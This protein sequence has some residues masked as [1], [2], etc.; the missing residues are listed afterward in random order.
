ME[1]RKS[2]TT[3]AQFGK[4]FIELILEGLIPAFNRIER[5]LFGLSIEPD[6]ERPWPGAFVLLSDDE[7]KLLLDVLEIN[8]LQRFSDQLNIEWFTRAEEIPT[9]IDAILVHRSTASSQIIFQLPT[10]ERDFARLIFRIGII[11][12]QFVDEEGNPL[13]TEL[14][15]WYVRGVL[16]NYHPYAVYMAY[17]HRLP[18]MLERAGKF[19]VPFAQLLKCMAKRY[20]TKSFQSDEKLLKEHVKL[21][22]LH[23]AVHALVCHLPDKIQTNEL[24]KAPHKLE[25]FSVDSYVQLVDKFPKLQQ[26]PLFIKNLIK[27][28]EK[29]ENE[30]PSDKTLK[31]IKTHIVLEMFCDRFGMYLYENYLKY[32]VYKKAFQEFLDYDVTI[33]M[34]L[35]L[36]AVRRTD[37]DNNEDRFKDRAEVKCLSERELTKLKEDLKDS[38]RSHVLIATFENPILSSEERMLFMQFLN[39]LRELDR[40]RKI[41]LFNEQNYTDSR[42]VRHTLATESSKD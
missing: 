32:Q 2:K 17:R 10:V 31:N 37:E 14:P 16:N 6:E 29:V 1:L 24:E 19:S 5:N 7:V 25:E 41:L 13:Y 8:G 21:A 18:E 30:P 35:S 11:D 27:G 22:L 26:S 15:P 12:P 28:L 9:N 42:F 33:G 4:S 3:R 34:V 23:E 20:E 38:E 40:E 39:L 36:E